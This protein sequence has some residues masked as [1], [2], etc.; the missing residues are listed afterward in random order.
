MQ[1]YAFIRINQYYFFDI[2]IE[3]VSLQIL[4]PQIISILQMAKKEKTA[5]LIEVAN[6]DLQ[7]VEIESLIH[8][9]RGKQVILDR[10]W[11]LYTKLIQRDL[12]SR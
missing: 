6:C 10:D 11:Q 1:I 12:T 9:I 7:S 8:H 2:K 4:E 3:A 5:E